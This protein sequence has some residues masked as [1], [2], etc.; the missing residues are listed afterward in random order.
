MAATYEPIATT[1]LSTTT[2][3]FSF[4]GIANTWTDLRLVLVS[5]STSGSDIAIR[6]NSSSTGYS[7]TAI[8]GT[9]T[10]ALSYRDTSV[11]QIRFARQ[12]DDTTIPTLKTVDIFSYAGSTYKTCLLTANMDKN[13]DGTVCYTVGLWQNT[14]AITAITVYRSSGNFNA[15]TTAT[16]YGI[17][18]A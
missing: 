6:F 2:F 9:G 12:G 10:S 17:K 8:E 16:L 18:A 15:G 7:N 11:S 1:T 4:T 5:T 3:N 14:S 13:G